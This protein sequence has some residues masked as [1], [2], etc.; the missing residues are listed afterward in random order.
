M[1][2]DT[3]ELRVTIRSAREA[4]EK[5]ESKRMALR[6]Y[7]DG[8][9]AMLDFLLSQNSEANGVISVRDAVCNVLQGFPG[10]PM[11]SKEIAS[12]ID[13]ESTRSKA[14][15]REGAVD[16]AV[17]GLIDRGDPIEKAGPRMWVWKNSPEQPTTEPPDLLKTALSAETGVTD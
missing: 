15:S 11:S 2:L 16:G 6:Q 8:Q 17:L 4:L 3:N 14:K 13:W 5:A 9:Q 12:H 1:E 7:I 10:S